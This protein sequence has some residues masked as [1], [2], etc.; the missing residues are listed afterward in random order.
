MSRKRAPPEQ[1]NVMDPKRQKTA[2]R[3]THPQVNITPL[4]PGPCTLADVFSLTDNPGI[5]AFNA[6][7]MVPADLAAKVSVHAVSRIDP[8]ILELAISVSSTPFGRRLATCF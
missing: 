2:L 4:P 6:A 8:E 1:A 3:T 5:K 7:A